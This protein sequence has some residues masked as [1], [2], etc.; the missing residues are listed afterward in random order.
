MWIQELFFVTSKRGKFLYRLWVGVMALVLPSLLF[1]ACV[2]TD[3]IEFEDAVNHP[4]VVV[5]STP[6]GTVS[7]C[8][9]D[10]QSFFVVMEDIDE[11]D[12]YDTDM[13]GLISLINEIDSIPPYPCNDPRPPVVPIGD[14]SDEDS[15]LIQ[16]TCPVSVRLLDLIPYGVLTTVHLEVSDLGY[17]SGDTP[18]EGAYVVQTDWVLEVESCE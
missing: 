6:R 8:R 11:D 5:A 16:I 1:T 15:T 4:P 2:V 3:S 14:D 7:V 10:D 17:V 13:R 18:Q 9:G 12:P